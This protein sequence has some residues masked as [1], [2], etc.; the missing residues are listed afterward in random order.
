VNR[1]TRGAGANQHPYPNGAHREAPHLLRC[2]PVKKLCEQDMTH[3]WGLQSDRL[4]T[5]L[6]RKQNQDDST[7]P[8]GAES[9]SKSLQHVRTC[10]DSQVV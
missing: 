4:S 10:L 9:E 7:N 1:L 8:E 6:E 2:V 3:V 5:Y